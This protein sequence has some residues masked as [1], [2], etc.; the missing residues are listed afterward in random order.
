MQNKKITAK[1][2]WMGKRCVSVLPSSVLSG[3]NGEAMFTIKTKNKSGRA[4]VTFKADGLR[5][6]L[7]VV[8]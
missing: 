1:I 7:I 6:D 2:N 3:E 5:K 8:V 4:T